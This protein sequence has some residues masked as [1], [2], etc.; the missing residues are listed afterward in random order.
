MICPGLWF[1][2][3]VALVRA[4]DSAC[5]SPQLKLQRGGDDFFLR[6]PPW[7]LRVRPAC[8]NKA[9]A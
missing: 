8:W 7:R 5:L 3:L 1:E 9:D 2:R 4:S 6:P